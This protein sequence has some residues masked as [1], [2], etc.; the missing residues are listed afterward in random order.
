MSKSRKMFFFVLITAIVMGWVLSV[1]LTSSATITSSDFLKTD[2]KF[3]KNNYGTGSVINLRGTN[4]GGWLTQE[5]WMSPLGEFAHDRTGWTAS[6]SVNSGSAGSAIDGD[7]TTC[8]N[9]G[10]NQAN[11]QW[12]QVN[13]GARFYFNRIYI[14]AASYMGDYPRG[15]QVLVSNDG[16][17]WTDVASGSGSEQNTILRFS[18]QVAQYIKVV[19]TGSSGTNY[20]SIAEFNVF[21]DPTV[22]SAGMSATASSTESGYSASNVF[23]GNINTRWT[24]GTAQASGQWFQINLGQNTSVGRLLIDA[25][26]NSTGDY[27]R[28]YEVYG[29]TDGI[30]W[31]KC[32]CAY[33]TNRITY[34]EFWW[35]EWVQYLKIVQTGSS[36]NWWSIAD[37]S[38]YTGGEFDRNGWTL[39]A[40][41]TGG[42][43][44]LANAKDGNTN[45][46]WSPGA[47]QANGQWFQADMGAMLTFDQIQLNSGDSYANDYPRSY[48]VEVSSDGSTWTQVATGSGYNRALPINFPA[49]SARYIKITETGSASNWWSIAEIN[50]FLNNDDYDLNLYLKDKFGAATRDSIIST[51]QD[52]WITAADLDNIAD[53]GMNYV[54]LPIGWLNLLNEDGTWRSNPWTKI[55]WVVDQCSQR[56]IYVLLDLHG[57]PG[58]DCPWGSSGRFGMNPNEFWTNTTYQDWVVSIWQAIATRYN[59]NA[60]VA[61]YDLMNEPLLSYNE[62]SSEVSQ[63]FNYYDRLYDAVRAIDTNHTIYIA[64]FFDW[65]NA[66][67]PSTYGWTNVVYEVHPYDMPGGKDWTAQNNLVTSKI[68]DVAAKQNDSNWNVPVLLGEYSLYHYDDVWSRWMSGLNAIKASW[69]NW[70]YKVRGKM[71]EGIG[72]YWGFYNTANAQI[73]VINNDSSS[74]ISSKYSQFGTSNFQPNTSLI[75]TAKKHAKGE[76]WMAS[77]PLDQTGWTATASSTESGSSPSNALDWDTNTRWSSGEAQTS[78]QWFQVNMGS[79]KAFDQITIETKSTDKFDYPR[80]Y[81]V[82]VSNDGS[83]WSTVKTGIGFGWKVVISLDPQ[84]AQYVKVVQTGS[85]PSWWTVGELHIYSEAAVDRTG[86]TASASVTQFGSSVGNAVDGNSSTRWSTG[87]TQADGQWFQVDMGKMQTFNRLVLD[88]G[89]SSNDYPRGYQVQVSNDGSTWTTVASGSNSNADLL[90]EFPVQYARYLKVVQ[91]GTSTSWWSIHELYLYGEQ[92]KSNSGWSASASSTEQGGAAGNAI[93][94]NSGTR[95]STGAAQ[96]SGQWFQVDMGSNQW[97]NHILIDSGSST[98]DYA[99]KYLVQV[100]YDGTNWTTIAHSEGTEQTVTVNF[101]IV[102]ARYIK[103][104]LQGSSGSWWSIHDFRVFK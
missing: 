41:Q 35:S 76:S 58:G 17:N 65:G 95:W 69:T 50:V 12:F 85:S 68:A 88:S 74:T 75:N 15:Y 33:G 39:S 67:T 31:T 101:P 9:T 37:V 3:I 22:N 77:V 78:G 7:N 82:Q 94:G 29:S 72:G 19:Q 14:N 28:S 97:F 57:L 38:V 91:T 24:S 70:S 23:D 62:G 61:G 16:S 84:Y 34:I 2:G 32:A 60:A 89:A 98:G 36:S 40:S 104:T 71:S 47:S 99:R 55:D 103:V 48:K 64:A 30:N 11:G 100:S 73:P 1:P 66:Y 87:T 93:D 26:P 45:T 49:V 18:P 54:R 8:W 27:P 4:L 96:A 59:G 46:V 43:T 80:G 90:A 102:E 13:M 56:G 6:A 63:K 10:A 81:E 44:S 42:G 21:S 5:D 53:M 25:G 83:S 79:K 86:W 92:E 52:T 51:H 20:W